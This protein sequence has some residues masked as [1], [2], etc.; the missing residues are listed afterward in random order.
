MRL[1]FIFLFWIV[2]GIFIQATLVKSYSPS[3][4]APDVLLILV[5][6][7][8]LYFRSIPGLLACFFIGLT[9]DFASAQFVGPSAAGSVVAFCMV[10]F[11]SHKVYADKIFAVMLITFLCSIAKS[12]MFILM[13]VA[14]LGLTLWD[15]EVVKTILFEAL[16]TAA[17]AP[18]VLKLLRLKASSVRM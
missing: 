2:I 12:A 15:G 5:V 4:L 18:V 6:S 10:I 9:A 8:A 13:L 14:Y 3:A 11:L 7:I 16:L 1:A 17:F